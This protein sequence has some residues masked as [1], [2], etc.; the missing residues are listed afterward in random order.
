V[1]AGHLSVL[2]PLIGPIF[3]P[4]DGPLS[5]WPNDSAVESTQWA[6]PLF[7]HV[8]YQ[9]HLWASLNKKFK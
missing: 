3:C 1:R 7:G 9:R 8:P 5:W 6:E 4:A 2:I